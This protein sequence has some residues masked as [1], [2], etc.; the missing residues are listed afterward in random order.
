MRIIRSVLILTLAQ[1]LAG[2]AVAAKGF[3]MGYGTSSCGQ[4][5]EIMQSGDKEQIGQIAGW[6]LG[7]WS[8]ISFQRDQAFIDKLKQAGAKKII[9]VT[10]GQCQKAEPD[11]P[12]VLITHQTIQSV[13]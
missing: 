13:K 1:G 11:T 3:P 10:L 12:L 8:A 4:V 2:P 9:Q 7:Y 6:I 5:L